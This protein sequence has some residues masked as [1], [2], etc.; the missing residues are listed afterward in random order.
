MAR[1]ATTGVATLVG[2]PRRT[3]SAVSQKAMNRKY[4]HVRNANDGLDSLCLICGT[5]VASADNEWS[6]LDYERRH[7]CNR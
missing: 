1:S 7:I 2:S 3:G 4:W 6:L 5:I